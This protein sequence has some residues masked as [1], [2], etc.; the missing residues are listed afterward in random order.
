MHLQDWKTIL[1]MHVVRDICH[2]CFF[3]CISMKVPLGVILKNENK[4]DEMI[5]VLEILHKYVHKG[6]HTQFAVSIGRAFLPR[7]ALISFPLV[8]R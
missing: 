2:M 1:N 7:G 8:W 6:N 5:D 3:Y 4:L